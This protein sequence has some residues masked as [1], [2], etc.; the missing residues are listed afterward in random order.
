MK[1]VVFIIATMLLTSC[2]CLEQGQPHRLVY[3]SA[4]T[5]ATDYYVTYSYRLKLTN[6]EDGTLPFSYFYELATHYVDTVKTYRPLSS[7][8]FLGQ[9]P[10]DSLPVPYWDNWDERKKYI[11][12]DFSFNTGPEKDTATEQRRVTHVKLWKNGHYET[13]TNIDSLLHS[14][15]PLDAG[16]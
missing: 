16:L 14:S 11:I 5:M 1:I 8:Y 2:S 12:V 15:K 4:D 7:L 13:Y 6:Y 3:Y 9:G 10:C